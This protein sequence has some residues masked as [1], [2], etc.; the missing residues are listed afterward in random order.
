MSTVQVNPPKPK[1]RWIQFSLRMFLAFVAVVA[2]GCGWF[3]YKLNQAR[4]QRQAVEAIQRLG[5]HV[6]YDY[7]YKKDSRSPEWLISLFGL[8]CFHFVECVSFDGASVTDD[9]LNQAI[10]PLCGLLKLRTLCLTSTHITDNGLRFVSGLSQLHE[11]TLT[12]NLR[13]TDAGLKHLRKLKALSLLDLSSTNITDNGL[14]DLAVLPSLQ[15]LILVGTDISDAGLK[16]VDQMKTLQNL[17]LHHTKVTDSGVEKLKTALPD[18]D[19]R[20]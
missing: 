11:L 3:A 12:G 15:V 14:A 7:T 18:L 17:L 5:G 10:Q 4:E 16:Y 8:D 1:R 13:I 6:A 9:D 2:V 19:A 20:R